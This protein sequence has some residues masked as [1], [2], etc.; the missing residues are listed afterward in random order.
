MAAA[1]TV[2]PTKASGFW[3]CVS[4][5][6]TPLS[7]GASASCGESLT[8]P[9]PPCCSWPS[10]ARSRAGLHRP[11][12]WSSLADARGMVCV[13]VGFENGLGARWSTGSASSTPSRCPSHNHTRIRLPSASRWLPTHTAGESNGRERPPQLVRSSASTGRARKRQRWRSGPSGEQSSF[14]RSELLFG[15]H[16]GVAVTWASLANSSATDS[17]GPISM[18]LGTG[19]AGC[20][21]T[22]DDRYDRE[23]SPL[24]MSLPGRTEKAVLAIGDPDDSCNVNPSHGPFVCVGLRISMLAMSDHGQCTL[25]TRAL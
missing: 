20:A 24:P 5:K 16:P 3:H 19:Y 13:A 18:G 2:S 8:C 4:P 22:L 10:T 25:E 1:A 7:P 9:D 17:A 14:L 23:P 6:L 15:Q 11:S 21:H 12:P